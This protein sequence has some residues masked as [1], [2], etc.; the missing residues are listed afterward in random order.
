ML[1]WILAL[2]RVSLGIWPGLHGRIKRPLSPPV[3]SA[4]L[5]GKSSDPISQPCTAL[6]PFFTFASF[7]HV[8]VLKVNSAV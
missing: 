5:R 4:S 7:V 2:A 8:S 6:F 3:D 1:C